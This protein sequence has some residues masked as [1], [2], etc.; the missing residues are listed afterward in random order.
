[1]AVGNTKMAILLPPVQVFSRK[2]VRPKCRTRD[3]LRGAPT[4]NHATT[5]TFCLY[6]ENKNIYIKHY[7]FTCGFWDYRQ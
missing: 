3:P 7:C 2:E 5:Q 6:L 4:P 1:M